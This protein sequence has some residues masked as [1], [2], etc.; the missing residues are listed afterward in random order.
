MTIRFTKATR[1]NGVDGHFTADHPRVSVRPE[2]LP[3][4]LYPEDEGF[5][6]EFL[7][8]IAKACMAHDNARYVRGV[9]PAL[10]KIIGQNAKQAAELVHHDWPHE[11]LTHA[12]Q[13]VTSPWRDI[14]GLQGKFTDRVVM[15]NHLMGWAAHAVSPNSFAAKWHYMV[16]RPEEVAGAIAR[17]ELDAPAEVRMLL[18][19]MVPQGMLAQ[20]QRRFTSYPE[21]SPDHPAYN[22][23]HSAAAGAAATVVK[24]L[25]DLTE[26]DQMMVDMTAHNM[27][28]FRTVAGVHYP[29]DNRVGLWLG[30]ETVVR[31]L[32]ALMEQEY[33]VPGDF[34]A[35]VLSTVSVDWG[36]T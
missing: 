12:A 15:L 11:I 10:E 23:M 27:A 34:I 3:M 26:A 5:W 8:T 17:G 20:D 22:A 24:V 32:P 30:Q 19:D 18:F 28:H 33:G 2:E 36:G 4:P 35:S 31:L 6:D 1:E 9:S 25:F 13:A 7:T 14:P 29:Q 21:G 16:P